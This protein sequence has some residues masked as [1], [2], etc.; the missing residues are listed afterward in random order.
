MSKY[1]T[2]MRALWWI[3]NAVSYFRGFLAAPILAVL[4]LW[5]LF[6]RVST[7]ELRPE[8]LG[9]YNLWA[10]WLVGAAAV[11]DWLDGFLAKRFEHYG[12]RTEKGAETDAYCDKFL[13][14]AVLYIAI[15]VLYAVGLYLILYLPA[16]CYIA[17]YSQKTTRMRKDELI[18]KPNRLAQWKTAILMGVKVAAFADVVYIG[19]DAI[20][21][22]CAL[23]TAL[24]AVLCIHAM[25]DYKNS[26]A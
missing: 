4:Y 2:T 25:E 8:I 22:A 23:A 11:S 9:N 17:Y 12:W 6:A 1:E 26:A 19:S 13:G 5:V 18:K 21:W 3:P 16:L 10:C 20:L 24:A 14:I 7:T 15:P